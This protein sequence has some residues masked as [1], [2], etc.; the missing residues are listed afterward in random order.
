MLYLYFKATVEDSN[1]TIVNF[2]ESKGESPF[3]RGFDRSHV[4]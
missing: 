3:T 1:K 2:K 4:D